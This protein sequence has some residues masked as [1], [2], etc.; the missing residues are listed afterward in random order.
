MSSTPL[1]LDCSIY[2]F[3]VLCPA[4][5]VLSSGVLFSEKRKQDVLDHLID[6]FIMRYFVRIAQYWQCPSYGTQVTSDAEV[7][8]QIHSLRKCVVGAPCLQ[9]TYRDTEADGLHT[10]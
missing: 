10:L 8:M 7:N 6:L 1:C 4:C 9:A 3:E 2:V 5:S